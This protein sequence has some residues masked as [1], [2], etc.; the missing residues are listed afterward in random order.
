MAQQQLIVENFKLSPEIGRE[1]VLKDGKV[2]FKSG[3]FEELLNEEESPKKTLV[4]EPTSTKMR[5]T[6]VK[7]LHQV[8][9]NLKKY[10]KPIMMWICTDVQAIDFDINGAIYYRDKLIPGSNLGEILKNIV[11]RRLKPNFVK[12]E[13]EVLLSLASTSNKRVLKCI[14][15]KKIRPFLEVE[16]KSIK[17]Y[18]P[19][20]KLRKENPILWRKLSKL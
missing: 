20:S 16:V 8:P 14:H 3:S 17:K 2:Q 1:V 15:P 12:G 13:K 18:V 19:S 9:D 4:D 6:M 5:D 10:A 7:I 11:N